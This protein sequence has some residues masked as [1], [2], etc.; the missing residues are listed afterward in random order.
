[1]ANEV[2]IKT[3]SVSLD[4]NDVASATKYHCQISNLLDFTAPEFSDDTL[5]PSQAA[6]TLT[7]GEGK[8]YWRWKAYVSGSWE[9]WSEVSSFIYNSSLA[10]EVSATFWKFV[11]KSDVTDYYHFELFIKSDRALP[12]H[13]RRAMNRNRAGKMMDEW[14]ATK[15]KITLDITRSYLGQHEKAEIL[16]FYNAHTSFYLVT[17]KLNQTESDYNY[18]AW[19][20]LFVKT[21][22]LDTP[23]GNKLELEEV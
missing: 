19:E 16:R 21:P 11:N 18:R 2:L 6:H 12:E 7:G 23:G 3:T 20:V 9:P 8:Y 10:S 13:Y 5:V 1:M 22:Q 17:R 14:Y 4:W 15:A